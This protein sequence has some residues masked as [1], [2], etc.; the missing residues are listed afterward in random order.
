MAFE[1]HRFLIGGL[2]N[3]LRIRSSLIKFMAFCCKILWSSVACNS[4]TS[5]L[6]EDLVAWNMVPISFSSISVFYKKTLYITSSWDSLL[7]SYF[8]WPCSVPFK[9]LSILKY[10]FLPSSVPVPVQLDWHSLIFNL[11]F[12][13]AD[14]IIIY[15]IIS[16]NKSLIT[17]S[18]WLSTG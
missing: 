14:P 10:T 11:P 17:Y 4:S 12:L 9:S 8:D 2:I 7:L 1:K 5:D 15:K 6:S 16:L 18:I 3:L 13:F